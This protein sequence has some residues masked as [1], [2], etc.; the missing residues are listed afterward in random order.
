M[1]TRDLSHSNSIIYYNIILVPHGP[2]KKINGYNVITVYFK[3]GQISRVPG[4][5]QS[6]K[7]PSH[8]VPDGWVEIKIS[9]CRCHFRAF[10]LELDI[11]GTKNIEIGSVGTKLQLFKVGN[12]LEKSKNPRLCLKKSIEN[13]EKMSNIL[14][15]TMLAE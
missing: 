12:I 11:L 14:F 6:V 15:S 1:I 8:L 10:Q 13:Y 5:Y 9:G 3:Y 4:S 2:I 7:Y